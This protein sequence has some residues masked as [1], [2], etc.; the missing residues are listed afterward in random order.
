[1]RCEHMPVVILLALAIGL[2][3]PNKAFAEDARTS[4]TTVTRSEVVTTG[5]EAGLLRR[6]PSLAH[7]HWNAMSAITSARQPN[8]AMPAHPENSHRPAAVQVT[9]HYQKPIH[10][11]L[12]F[13]TRPSPTAARPS[14][15][16]VGEHTVT[17]EAKTSIRYSA[18]RPDA[19]AATYR[20]GYQNSAGTGGS[21]AIAYTSQ[22]NV[23]GKIVA[24]HM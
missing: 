2:L 4:Y 5:W 11:P 6:D 18:R 20:Q 1:V 10:V 19:A 17:T 15:T 9:S 16:A 3:V 12:P 23:H 8:P 13:V 14:P 24:R 22:A 7:W 21:H